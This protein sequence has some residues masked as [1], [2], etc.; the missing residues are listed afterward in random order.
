VKSKGV[1]HASVPESHNNIF[2]YR[3][4]YES[5]C[6]CVSRASVHAKRYFLLIRLIVATF[7]AKM[8]S[9]AEMENWVRDSAQA[10][11]RT[12]EWKIV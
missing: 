7:D 3:Q 4:Q 8:E 5:I 1:F 12:F 10:R 6:L 2:P 11:A 9:L